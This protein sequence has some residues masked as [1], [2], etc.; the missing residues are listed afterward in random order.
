MPDPTKPIWVFES[1]GP[2]YSVT[3]DSAYTNTRNAAFV[4]ANIA[5]AL[6][7]GVSRMAWT[8]Y[9]PESDSPFFTQQ[10]YRNIPL[11]T[12][13]APY[14]KKQSY[15]GYGGL[16]NRLW[17]FSDVTDLRE[18]YQNGWYPEDTN[19]VF[20]ER[21]RFPLSDTLAQANVVWSSRP[22]SLYLAAYTTSPAPYVQITSV[23]LDTL[24]LPD[25]VAALGATHRLLIRIGPNPIIVSANYPFDLSRTSPIGIGS[26]IDVNEQLVVRQ[27]F[28]E[29]KIEVQFAL[30]LQISRHDELIVLD[31]GG[32]AVRTIWLGG[33]SGGRHT[34]TWDMSNERQERVSA[35]VYFVQL[36]LGTVLRATRRVIVLR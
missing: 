32:R 10:A 9:P 15:L 19:T 27:R 33:M 22:D 36:R 16:T 25:S 28:G 13:T 2:F 6:G 31:I 8:F 4:Y 34:L 17:R 7:S 30:P 1:G 14:Q 11:F 35:G 5:E 23:P 12:G 18:T 21:Y 29:E 20:N 26:T 3:N 24:A